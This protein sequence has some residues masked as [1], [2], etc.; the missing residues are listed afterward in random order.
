MAVTTEA[1]AKEATVEGEEALAAA[2]AV[3]GE[4][5]IIA[6]EKSAGNGRVGEGGA[7][8][9]ADGDPRKLSQEGVEKM[10]EEQEARLRELAMNVNVF[11]PYQV[12][13]YVSRVSVRAAER[14]RN[15]TERNKN[16]CSVTSRRFLKDETVFRSA[17]HAVRSRD[18]VE[19]VHL[20][21]LK[22][23]SFRCV[24]SSPYP[25]RSRDEVGPIYKQALH[26]SRF[27]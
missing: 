21:S 20:L 26:S 2:A 25:V 1:K 11:M 7:G 23:V 27:L 13:A 16:C 14:P 12:G 10:K 6:D 8:G 24:T 19:C 4:T 22:F 17:C 5:E 9:E 3:V 15:G 18:Q